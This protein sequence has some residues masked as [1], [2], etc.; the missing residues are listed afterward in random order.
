M[1]ADIYASMALHDGDG[2]GEDQGYCCE[3][4]QHGD[5]YKD[6]AGF[7]Y[8]DDCWESYLESDLESELEPAQG[9]HLTPAAPCMLHSSSSDPS[10]F[11]LH[12]GSVGDTH[13]FHSLILIPVYL[14]VSMCSMS[15]YVLYVFM[16]SMSSLFVK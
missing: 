5:G 8:C 4:G 6:E 2:F 12:L 15:L 3:C 16:C 14:C 9:V 10:L 7:F 11:T 13:T 1:E